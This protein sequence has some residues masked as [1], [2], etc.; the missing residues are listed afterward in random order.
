[1]E[2]KYLRKITN[3]QNQPDVPYKSS[4]LFSLAG[5]TFHYVLLNG[6]LAVI[7]GNSDADFGDTGE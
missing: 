6:G 1:M 3:G 7:D 4:E 5:W 2:M